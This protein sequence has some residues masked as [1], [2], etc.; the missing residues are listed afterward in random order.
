MP[1]SSARNKEKIQVV[2]MANAAQSWATGPL[3]F[4]KTGCPN[5][6]LVASGNRATANFE[7]WGSKATTMHDSHLGY[8]D[9]LFNKYFV[10]HPKDEQIKLTNKQTN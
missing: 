1:G 8:T 2:Q 4:L 6:I 5:E 3:F 7:H 10:L 9:T